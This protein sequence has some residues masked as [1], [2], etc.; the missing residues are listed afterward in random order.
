MH[1]FPLFYLAPLR[2]I[3]DNIFRNT[4]ESHFGKFDYLLTPFIPTVTSSFV[5]PSHVRDIDP[6]YNDTTRVIPQI[7]G[8]NPKDIITLANHFTELGYRC[9]NL[10]LGCP[11]PQITR[12]KRG[13]GLLAYPDILE[14]I[15]ESVLQNIT[16][17]FSVKVRLGLTS[18]TELENVIPV[19]NKY[20][21]SEVII[22]PRTSSQMYDGCVN[23]GFFEKYSKYIQHNVTYNGDLWSLELYKKYSIVFPHINRWMLGRGVIENP[24]LLN[25]LK[26]ENTCKKDT[27]IVRA[28]HDELFRKNS[29]KLFGPAHIL[30]KMK[31][32][33]LYI[34]KS[35]CNSKKVLKVIQKKTSLD[36]YISTVKEIFEKE[37][38]L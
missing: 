1:K 23:L 5:N 14:S 6:K 11:H 8:N 33:W 17:Y 36:G 16:C 21:L 9:V 15:L 38:L 3:T 32:F 22:H 26:S 27:E 10:N 19:L 35:F 28:F 2:G 12:K 31:E 29:E 13:S 18:E 7:I 30:G 34:S 4:F 25:E 20:P 24:F 37:P